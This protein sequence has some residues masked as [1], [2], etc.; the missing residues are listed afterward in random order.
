MLQ[1]GRVEVIVL[2]GVTW[3]V[4]LRISQSR[5]F[6]QC[7]QLDVHRHARRK[8]V[9]VHLV[10]IFTFRLQEERM[11]LLVGEGDELGFYAR[12]VAGTGALDL[13]II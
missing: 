10:R 5:D 3:S 4:D 12:A 7:L 2:D 9:Q 1:L 8:S 6:V 11:L 13:T